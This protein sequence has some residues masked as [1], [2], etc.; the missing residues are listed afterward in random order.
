[1]PDFDKI[2]RQFKTIVSENA[3]KIE[4][5]EWNASDGEMMK[6]VVTFKTLQ[7]IDR[8]QTVNSAAIAPHAYLVK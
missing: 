7:T 5:T 6:V 8:A 4:I 3:G 1:M 2:R